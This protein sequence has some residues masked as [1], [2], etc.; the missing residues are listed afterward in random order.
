MLTNRITF[1][2]RVASVC[3]S[4]HCQ[5]HLNNTT[6]CFCISTKPYFDLDSQLF[7]VKKSEFQWSKLI[8]LVFFH[9]FYR[10]SRCIN[11]SPNV[12][13]A[14]NNNIS[15]SGHQGSI[16]WGYYSSRNSYLPLILI[17]LCVS[18]VSRCLFQRSFL[19][20]SNFFLMVK[21]ILNMYFKTHYVCLEGYQNICFISFYLILYGILTGS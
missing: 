1:H 7:A 2:S 4:P 11:A 13:S 16:H 8:S 9:L 6:F 19:A 17:C 20:R 12:F 14:D 10:Y 5:V 3:E 18:G 15:K 21:V